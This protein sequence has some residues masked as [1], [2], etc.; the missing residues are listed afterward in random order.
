MKETGKQTWGAGLGRGVCE[1][2]REEIENTKT[3]RERIGL[4]I[5]NSK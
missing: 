5:E 1:H 3:L 2:S 4:L